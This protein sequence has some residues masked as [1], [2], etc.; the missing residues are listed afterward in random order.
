MLASV[1]KEFTRKSESGGTKW[2]NRFDSIYGDNKA[3]LP[4]RSLS[5]LEKN[6]PIL[7]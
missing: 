6:I 7:L 3:A 4:K 1:L 2:P 5:T